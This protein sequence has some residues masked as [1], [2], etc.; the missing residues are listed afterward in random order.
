MTRQIVRVISTALMAYIVIM[1]ATVILGSMADDGIILEAWYSMLDHLPF[2]KVLAP[3][4]VK[5]FFQSFDMGY[6]MSEYMQGIDALG[7][8]DVF[9]D[10]LTLLLTAVLFEAVS[11]FIMVLMGIKGRQGIHNILMKMIV[12]MVSALLCTFIASIVISNFYQQLASFPDIVQKAIS[13][14]TTFITVGGALGVIY[15]VL[16]AGIVSAVVYTFIKIVAINAF[17]VLVT[18]AAIF[19]LVLFLGEKAYLK[20]FSV[21]V[22]WGIAMIILIRVDTEIGERYKYW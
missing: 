4:C 7:P 9:E 21:I 15:F 20:M 11:N 3:L 2:S 19:L 18:Y 12:R 6:G 10:I 14:L 13:I 16:G 17:N 1:S 22:V 5:L 8:I